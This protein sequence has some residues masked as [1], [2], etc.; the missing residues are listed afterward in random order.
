MSQENV[1]AVRAMHE[2]FDRGDYDTALS[3]LAP[4]VVWHA[5][6][7]ITIGD[8]VFR[9]RD[10]VQRGFAL[11]SIPGRHTA[12]SRPRYAATVITCSSPASRWR[13][14]EGAASR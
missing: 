3:S 8:E 1:E 11:W 12:S 13:E 4:D 9:G 10:A 2:A 14:A 7:G 5:P 6:P